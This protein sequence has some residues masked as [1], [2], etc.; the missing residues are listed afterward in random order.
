Q[1]MPSIAIIGA[2]ARRAKFGN[3][4]VRAY[5]EGGYTVYPIHP[6]HS[7]VEGLAVY[8]SVLDVPEPIDVASFYVSPAVGLRV[9]EDV[10]RQGIGQVILNPGAESAELLRRAAELGIEAIVTCSILAIGRHPSEF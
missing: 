1:I 6:V 3:K 5:H 9:I 7:E 4:A 8:K 2:S 10:A